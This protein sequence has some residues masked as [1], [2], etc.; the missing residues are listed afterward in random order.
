MINCKQYISW[1]MGT[2]QYALAQ[3]KSELYRSDKPTCIRRL[4]E[5]D[6]YLRLG[7]D[8]SLLMFEAIDDLYLETS[9][10]LTV[11]DL[12]ANDWVCS[13]CPGTTL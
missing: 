7:P 13:T 9:S 4:N 8:G 11:T 2:L 12:L 1:E 6:M 5:P 10:D 3:L